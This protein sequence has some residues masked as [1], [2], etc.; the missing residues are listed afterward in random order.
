MKLLG[1]K[2]ALTADE[3]EQLKKLR[4]IDFEARR[5]EAEADYEK[6]MESIASNKWLSLA[7]AGFNI[8]SQPGGT[9]ALEGIGKGFT[10]S[11][12]TKDI[13]EG[14]KEERALAKEKK[15]ELRSISDAELDN[16]VRISGITRQEADNLVNAQIVEQDTKIAEATAGIAGVKDIRKSASE[17][18]T[19]FLKEREMELDYKAA[20]AKAKGT[21]KT[22]LNQLATRAESIYKT[23]VANLQGVNV[24]VLPD[25]TRS[26]MVDRKVYGKNANKVQT[27][28]QEVL[29]KGLNIAV[30]EGDIVKAS[31]K[32]TELLENLG[33]NT[34]KSTSVPNSSTSPSVPQ[35]K[36]ENGK[37]VPVTR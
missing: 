29:D 8:L 35:F 33:K 19:S 4:G 5:T 34:E 6:G 16:M 1:K 23:K 28:L 25:G 17:D 10:Q 36:I 13:M 3:L 7:N 22:T 21:N 11:G 14:A 37:L 18:V 9:T 12:F 27:E 2:A 24:R 20:L 26:V 32:M 30:N 31:E 15:K